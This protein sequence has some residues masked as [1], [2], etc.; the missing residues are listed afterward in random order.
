MSSRQVF[1]GIVAGIRSDLK[2]LKEDLLSI[3]WKKRRYDPFG[4]GDEVRNWIQDVF[5]DKLFEVHAKVERLFRDFNIGRD[6]PIWEIKKCADDLAFARGKGYNVGVIM[7]IFEELGDHIA[8]YDVIVEKSMG[9]IRKTLHDQNWE[10]MKRINLDNY[11]L[12]VKRTRYVDARDEL[13]TAKNAVKEGNWEEVLNHLRPAI[14]LALKEKFGFKWIKGY[15]KFFDDAGKYGLRL[16][17]YDMVYRYFDE[18]SQR[19]HEGR[20]HTPWECQEALEFVAKFIDRLD[21]IDIS[22]KEIEEFKKKSKS[23]E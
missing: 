23:V 2:Y 14:D 18:A 1:Q 3:M 9:T 22:D 10:P 16:P 4:R 11:T 21:L 12:P 15:K 13:S 7:G 17:S 19:L 20:V 6:L 8:K 5:L